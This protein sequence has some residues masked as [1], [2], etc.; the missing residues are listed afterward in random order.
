LIE[1]AFG[2]GPQLTLGVE[3]EIMILDGDTY[4][5]VGAV[6]VFVRESEGLDLPGTLKTELHASVV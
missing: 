6:D 4:D 3:E 2:A 1:N 5:P